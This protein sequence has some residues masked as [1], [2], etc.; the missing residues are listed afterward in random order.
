MKMTKISQERGIALITV[1]LLSVLMTMMTVSMIFISSNHLNMMGNIEEKMRALK[2]A[3]SMAEYALTKLNQDPVWGINATSNDNIT[4]TLDGATGSITFAGT[5]SSEYLSYNNLKNSVPVDRAT[6]GDTKLN[7][8]VPAYAAE[9]ICKGVAGNGDATKYLRVIFIRNDIFPY[10]IISEGKIFFS[11]GDVS[12]FGMKAEPNDPDAPEP[13]GNIHSNWDGSGYTDTGPESDYWSISKSNTSGSIF[14]NGG[15]ASAVGYINLDNDPNKFILRPNVGSEGK[16]DLEDIDTKKI[17]DEKGPDCPAKTDPATITGTTLYYV[18]DDPG[19]MVQ[20]LNSTLTDTDKEN[21]QNTN[22]PSTPGDAALTY[23]VNINGWENLSLTQ[24]VDN[25]TFTDVEGVTPHES[26]S[27][28]AE[29]KTNGWETIKGSTGEMTVNWT[30][31]GEEPQYDNSTVPPTLTGYLP[32]SESG[33]SNINVDMGGEKTFQVSPYGWSGAF[34]NKPLSELPPEEV[35]RVELLDLLGETDPGLA[36]LNQDGDIETF[37]PPGTDGG[38]LGM[39]FSMSGEIPEGKYYDTDAVIILNEDIYVD[40]SSNLPED[41]YEKDLPEITGDSP[42]QNPNPNV[43]QIYT[44]RE[45]VRDESTGEIKGTKPIEIT[46]DLNG[47]NIYSEAHMIMDAVVTGQGGMVTNGR[48]A[49]LQGMRSESIVSLAGEDLN[50][51]L[52]PGVPYYDINGYLYSKDDAKITPSEYVELDA[53]GKPIGNMNSRYTSKTARYPLHEDYS[54]GGKT[55]S[56]EG[57][58]GDETHARIRRDILICSPATEPPTYY[59]QFVIPEGTE[60]KYQGT[61]YDFSSYTITITYNIKDDPDTYTV[62]T[63]PAAPLP[64]G[65]TQDVL[66][67]IAMVI[68]NTFDSVNDRPAVNVAGCVV[69]LNENEG[70]DDFNKNDSILINGIKNSEVRFDHTDTGMGRVT[71]LRGDSFSVRVASWFEL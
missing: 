40:M 64:P 5:G 71:E 11:A 20:I 28:P 23:G 63:N 26:T 30:I 45:N 48:L 10:P 34:Q 65:C 22:L 49:Y 51:N 61:T 44:S 29:Y 67:G 27:W 14:G 47:H 42:V 9:I 38:V 4:I 12:I 69:G 52:Y 39:Q 35:E 6:I 50:I 41:D 31:S 54:A 57:F 58:S 18:P 33:T 15:I 53:N 68:A 60:I 7:E 66:D 55:I 46:L 36:M 17:I 56:F 3:E 37:V 2:A 21:I 1:L 8:P 24:T 25:V 16:L 70:P 19:K 62:I 32:V 59:Y 13:P 43:F